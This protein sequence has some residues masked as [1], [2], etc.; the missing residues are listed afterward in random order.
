MQAVESKLILEDV[1]ENILIDD[2][3]LDNSFELS[4]KLVE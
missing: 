4:M 3:S 1:G 2:D